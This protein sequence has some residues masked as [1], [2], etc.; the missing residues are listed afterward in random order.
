MQS[1]VYPIFVLT[2]QGDELRRSKL[3]ATLEEAGLPYELFFGVDGRKGLSPTME[4]KVD[5]RVTILRNWRTLSDGEYACALSHQAIYE[6]IV[7]R[8]L[9]GGIILEDDVSIGAKFVEF[10]RTKAYLKAEMM[11]MFHHKTIVR[12]TAAVD[13]LNGVYGYRIAL[14]P[15]GAAGYSLSAGAARKIIDRSRPISAPADWPCNIARL[16]CLAL[17][18]QI[19]DHPLDNR[20]FSHLQDG[21]KNVLRLQKAP[22]FSR[23]RRLLY[24]DDWHLKF[25]RRLGVDLNEVKRDTK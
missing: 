24:L 8:H 22:P 2:L 17:D 7:R 13:V 11:L 15:Y 5:R 10:V 23:L 1:T 25:G 3:V 6:E 20:P 18:P 16:H 12:R 9:S 19:V 4:G 14:P 21:R